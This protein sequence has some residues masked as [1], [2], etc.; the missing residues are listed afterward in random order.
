MKARL[1]YVPGS[2]SS[3]VQVGTG[4]ARMSLAPGDALAATSPKNL[5]LG[6]VHVHVELDVDAHSHQ[7][8]GSSTAK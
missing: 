3:S 8:C 7:L 6:L 2:R 1:W 5:E 4:V